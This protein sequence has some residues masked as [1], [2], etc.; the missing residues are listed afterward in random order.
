MKTSWT[1]AAAA[2]L[3]LLAA[4]CG[5]A[6]APQGADATS[7][8]I[9]GATL[10]GNRR[11]ARAEAARL[12][13]LVPVPA[14]ARRLRSAPAGLSVPAMGEPGVT[15]LADAQQSWRLDLPVNAAASWIAVH[16]PAGLK[17]LGYATDSFSYLAGYDYLGPSGPAWGRAAELDVGVAPDGPNASFLRADGLVAWL[18]PVPFRDTRTGPR[19]RV[20][21][22][23][24]CPATD[25][26]I[27]GVRNPAAR[28]TRALL[29]AGPPAGALRC[30][31][32]GSNGKQFTLTAQQRLGPAR[33]RALAAAIGRI[34]LSHQAGPQY[35]CARDDGSAVLVA[36]AYPGG[37]SADLWAEVTGCATIS[38]GSIYAAGELP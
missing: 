9:G 17:R 6:P 32:S 14:G 22:A 24:R 21:T 12:L 18:D 2:A 23:G 34:P 20:L 3:C 4:G 26:G 35:G 29:P 5:T 31:Y 11:L 19:L 10:A 15:G 30:A 16:R 1:C 37:A 33:A 8:R 38:N 28:L 13:A 36:F 25:A 27:V 7:R